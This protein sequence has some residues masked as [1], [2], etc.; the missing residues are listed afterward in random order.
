MNPWISFR[1]IEYVA[2]IA[3]H[4]SISLAAQ[5][6]CITQPAL[7]IYLSKLESRLGLPLFER[8]G[9]RFLLTYAGTC[10]VEGGA[11]ILATRDHIQM[12]LDDILQSETGRLRVGFPYVRG[13]SLLPPALRAFRERYPKVEVLIDED[14]AQNL[15]TKL[16]G[17]EL[18]LIFISHM[19]DNSLLEYTPIL[20]DPIV[21]YASQA[22]ADGLGAARREGFE[23]PW[24][25]LASLGQTPFV[26]NFPNQKT[27]QIT[28]QMF[29]DYG[30]APPTAVQVQNQL[31]AI[32]LAAV[33]CGVYLAPEYF[34]YN[35]TFTTP[36][37]ILS[38][39]REEAYAMK[40]IAA[41]RKSA[42]P[43]RLLQEFRGIVQNVYSYGDRQQD[44]RK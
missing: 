24:I 9:K 32:H 29:A 10:V 14:N 30:L 35:M 16:T 20:S 26:L 12:Q 17:G 11:G 27:Y 44:K 28:M 1:D 42:A 13:I 22:F 4:G 38:V 34:S 5:D 31:T 40:L 7:S 18:D 19:G 37:V 41:W 39:G 33:G 43:N 23:Q 15:E 8:V 21:L 36:P 6:L 25:D 2:A 3:K